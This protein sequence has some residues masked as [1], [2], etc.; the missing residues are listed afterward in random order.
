M[1][2]ITQRRNENREYKKITG[3][4]RP[5]IKWVGG[6]RQILS[7][8]DRYLPKKYNKYI[9]PF[10]G[11]GALFFYLLQENA[12]IIDNNPD[13]I[14]C[15]EIIRGDVELLIDSLKKH[16]NKKEYFYNSLVFIS[17][18]KLKIDQYH[19]RKLLPFVERFPLPLFNIILNFIGYQD[20][21]PGKRYKIMECGEIKFA[22]NI[23]YEAI[24]PNFIRRSCNVDNKEA[25]LIINA[26][27]DSWYGKTIEPKMHL[28]MTGFRAIENRKS[29]V[30]STCTGYSAIFNPAGDVVYESPLF[31][32]DFVVKK[33]ALLEIKTIYR[34]WGW[35]F[36][37]G[38]AIFLVL[39][40]L[41]SSYRKLKF[42]YI[43][44]ELIAKKIHKRDL[45]RLWME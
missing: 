16:K 34:K 19:K 10:V 4:P 33:I 23:C 31:K 38:L 3:P 27:N 35:F 14:N 2:I 11:G 7:Q 17:K 8:I 30:R 9:E 5:F 29:L 26:T 36:I 43:K 28:H 40:I 44:S 41:F 21:S 42:R 20:F 15:Y 13:L 39:I 37:W 6:K 45:Y 22:P 32:Q 12:I 18:D 25:N 1:D 24:I